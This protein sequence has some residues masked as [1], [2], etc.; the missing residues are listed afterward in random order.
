MA[1][2]FRAVVLYNPEAPGSRPLRC[3]QR[4]LFLGS[5]EYNPQSRFV[6]RILKNVTFIRC[7]EKLA[8]YL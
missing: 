4:D 1:E 3:H 7:L 6:N 2:W 8:H 5:T